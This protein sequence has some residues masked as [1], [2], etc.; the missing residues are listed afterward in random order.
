[1]PDYV[2]ETTKHSCYSSIVLNSYSVIYKLDVCWAANRWLANPANC[3]CIYP[4]NLTSMAK[5]P[6]R[7]GRS[8]IHLKMSVEVQVQISPVAVCLQ[9]ENIN[10]V[11]YS[12][13]MR[14]SDQWCV[15]DIWCINRTLKSLE[16]LTLLLCKHRKKNHSPSIYFIY[17]ICFCIYH[18]YV[19]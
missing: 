17:I 1:M 7:L 13:P 16:P 14:E 15:G 4:A 10:A 2:R 12:A 8:P 19:M 3:T 9:Q 18:T 6:L 5:I 11:L